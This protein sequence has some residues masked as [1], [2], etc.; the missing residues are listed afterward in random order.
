MVRVRRPGAG[1]GLRRPCPARPASLAATDTRR[2]LSEPVEQEPG[3]SFRPG[4]PV[5]LSG[6]ACHGQSGHEQGVPPSV[7]DLYG[8]GG[9][10]AG[11]TDREQRPGGLHR[12]RSIVRC[13]A[14]D[15]GGRAAGWGSAFEL[16]AAV[17]PYHSHTS[18][19]G[20]RVRRPGGMGDLLG[21][22]HVERALV[23]VG[24]LRRARWHRVGVLG[25]EG[26]PSGWS[27]HARRTTIDPATAAKALTGDL[28][29]HGV[30]CA[31]GGRCRPTSSKC[32]TSHYWSDRVAAEA[33]AGWSWMPPNRHGVE[34]TM[35]TAPERGG[36][37]GAVVLAQR[38][39]RLIV[40]GN[41]RPERPQSASKGGEQAHRGLVDVGRPTSTVVDRAARRRRTTVHVSTFQSGRSAA[42]SAPGLVI[43]PS[44]QGRAGLPCVSGGK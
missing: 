2:G 4:D 44:T 28:M 29:Q 13:Q 7:R 9:G 37:T 32:G 11:G 43:M 39:S 14:R 12:W 36:R 6:T 15:A 25:G 23:G 8:R 38:R 22:P 5:R 42:E 31:A 33:A 18:G 19:R 26:P 20:R 35:T 34:G 16:P 27:G 30:E 24:G 3:G 40:W 17:I 41:L 10:G 1:T 21:R